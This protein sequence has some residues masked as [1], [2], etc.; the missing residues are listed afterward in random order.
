MTPGANSRKWRSDETKWVNSSIPIKRWTNQKPIRSE[1]PIRP[2]GPTQSNI[3][4]QCERPRSRGSRSRATI[5]FEKLV[6]LGVHPLDR[7]ANFR[8][9]L[10]VM[11][12]DFIGVFNER[13][14]SM[15][16]IAFAPLRHPP[17][18]RT[19]IRICQRRCLPMLLD[20]RMKSHV[21]IH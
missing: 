12:N 7:C 9:G 19:A 20:G 21:E 3:A 16:P 17:G 13:T 5:G 8:F 14:A 6:G 11:A 18:S 2:V 15:H 1:E 4:Y 10:N